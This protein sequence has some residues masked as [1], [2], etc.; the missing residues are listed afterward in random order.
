MCAAALWIA[1]SGV[2][3]EHTS[4][5]DELRAAEK[6]LQQLE[7]QF[8]A[9]KVVTLRGVVDAAGAGGARSPGERLWTLIFSLDGWRVDHG[10]V[11]TTVLTVRKRVTERELEKYRALID[12]YSVLEFRAR[13][14]RTSIFGTPEA[15]LEKVVGPSRDAE[16]IR[17]AAELQRPVQR[18]DALLGT[19]TLDRV[20]HQFD[21]TVAWEKKSITLSVPEDGFDRA[22]ATSHA[23]WAESQQ[24]DARIRS[25]AAEKLLDL[26]N[27][28]WLDD[29]ESEVSALE[30]A[31]RLDLQ[32]IVIEDDGSFTFWFGDDG[33]FAG[34]SITVSG[35]VEGGLKDAKIEG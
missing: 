7:Q 5:N 12:S 3:G 33:L 14:V 20:V 11:E 2:A 15:R 30:F 32:S 22:L 4:I 13:L 35:T 1:A 18:S 19:F 8:D 24:W 25:F 10:S 21:A 6:R 23:L 29:D 26:K 28:V 17:L 27:E 31:R 9:A 16:L 34:H